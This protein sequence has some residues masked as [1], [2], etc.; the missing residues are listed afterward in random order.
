MRRHARSHLV[1]RYLA[2]VF[3]AG[4]PE[5]VAQSGEIWRYFTSRD[6]LVE[7]YV[8]AVSASP[9]G[10]VWI[11]HGQVPEMS[12]F[13]G[14]AVKRLP[15][16]G[17]D[18]RVE[19]GA[20]G[21]LWAMDIQPGR[22]PE[23]LKVLSGGQWKRFPLA[24]IAPRDPELLLSAAGAQRFR[25]L[26][27]GRVLYLARDGLRQFD[28]AAG[29]SRSI[30]VVG[31]A[32][33]DLHAI[34][35]SGSSGF[36]LAGEQ[37][38]G[39]IAAGPSANDSVQCTAFT[40]GSPP[41]LHHFSNLFEDGNAVFGS[42]RDGQNRRVAIR[43]STE[44][45]EVLAHTAPEQD[46]ICGWAAS[47]GAA[48]ILRVKRSEQQ[49]SFRSSRGI[50]TPATKSK[51]LSGRIA[52][53][54][55][56]PGG[57]SWI[58]GALGLGRLAPPVW[59]PMGPP[60]ISDGI[61]AA[62]AGSSQRDI[63][64]LGVRSLW[65]LSGNRWSEEPLPG[66][67][68][69]GIGLSNG[70]SL[71]ATGDVAIPVHLN[72]P[73]MRLLVYSRSRN[74]FETPTVAGYS[75][76][77]FVGARSNGRAWVACH[78]T[79][80]RISL[81]SYDGKGFERLFEIPT[82]AH[83]ELPRAVAEL[84]DGSIWVGAFWRDSLFRYANGAVKKVALPAEASSMGVSAIA[85]LPNGNV[86]AAG[87]DLLLE[88][89]GSAWR[90]LQRKL[91]TVRAIYP[92]HDGSVWIAGGVGAMR[93]RDNGCVSIGSAD[94]L[95][96]AAAWA[97]FDDPSGRLLIGTT[98]GVR[99][100]EA[101]ADRDPPMAGI[102][103]GLNVARFAPGGEVRLVP[104]GRDRWGFTEES[105]LLFSYRLDA[106]PWSPF[107][108]LSVVA[109]RRIASGS[110]SIELRAMDRN[111]NIGP[112]AP[113]RFEVL[114]RWYRQP[115][116]VVF[117]LLATFI[118]IFAAYQHL[119]RHRQL[120]RL[121]E[122][123]TGQLRSDFE[124]RTRIQARFESIL[125]HAPALIYVKDL[126]ARYIVSNRRHREALG[127]ARDEIVGKTDDEIFGSGSAAP[128]GAK[129]GEVL[130]YSRVI[131]FEEADP[132]TSRTYLSIKCPLYDATGKP[133]AICG[134]AT[135]ITE[136]KQ[137][138]QRLQNS[139]RLESIGL[140]A[141]GVAHDFNNLLTVINGYAEMLLA[142]TSANPSV[143]ASLAEIRGAGERAAAL[144]AQL[145][146]F[147]RKQSVSPAVLN[148]G[149]LVA[150]LAN[151]LR[152]L[153]GE[154]VELVTRV[155]PDVGNSTIDAGQFQ[156]VLMNLAVNARDAMPGGGTLLIEVQNSVLDEDYATRHPDVRPGSYVLLAVSD[157]G[158]GMTPE[159]QAQAFEP[160]FTTKEPGKGT[161]LGLASVYGMVR[162]SGGWI[163]VYSEVG[164]GTTFKVY[165]PRT[166][167]PLPAAETAPK[168][169]ITGHETILVVEDQAEVRKLAVA[170]LRSYGY[171]VYEAATGA[172]AL[173]LC[174]E[175]RD[176]LQLLVTDVVMPGMDGYE[177]ARQV[178]ELLPNLKVL[179]MSGYTD[180]AI[181]R[182]GLLSSGVAYL[183]KPFT[184]ESL[185]EK[186][187]DVLGTVGPP[188]APS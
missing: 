82:D 9:S 165:L 92:A 91:E 154:N 178:N 62:I 102:P 141:G 89:D 77:T 43:A 127:K 137:L 6:G 20:G 185:G 19:E 56:Q 131:Q 7:S 79:H 46:G 181:T 83:N 45:T 164:R 27:K 23:G 100:R 75:R 1:P 29:R 116:L 64:F 4:T 184:P 136:F 138:Q 147:S 51:V 163:W 28:S 168:A 31:C 32:L 105:R 99:F 12:T 140:L 162:Q 84:R 124:E 39:R 76:C 94:G 67:P 65:I 106:G 108:E 120:A 71:L 88:Y 63:F 33:G 70:M 37:S 26:G 68:H 183:Q 132:H 47:N 157:T 8:G 30:R 180:I 21:E 139:Q 176:S 112:A 187:R 173:P 174:K 149:Q 53:I 55:V 161:G 5:V 57:V 103:P 129:D 95:P 85:Q 22:D 34:A 16:P 130:A 151:M 118:L 13:D 104:E 128:F 41:G 175:M 179:Y 152:R 167:A 156:Q 153:I 101:A 35:A 110:H 182:Q 117:G 114:A 49:L 52:D 113:Y 169:N 80:D 119:S 10:R 50:E 143:R 121:V 146:A 158:V 186:V 60:E 133:N 40:R 109:L 166:D 58:A 61:I 155:A 111:F 15:S 125:D 115:V 171:R 59:Q 81:Y 24:D 123:K 126:E 18:V 145:L 96:E 3:L 93:C 48:W 90:V 2:F 177:L 148:P 11:T 36:W 74:R 160:F 144:T 72:G 17:I 69:T 66:P 44:S 14:F 98:A 159:V 25:P 42:A 122:M 170:A 107:E 142:E 86:W 172:K 73:A 78:E 188:T 87:R 134:I 38:V 97:V 54:A 150:E 135:D